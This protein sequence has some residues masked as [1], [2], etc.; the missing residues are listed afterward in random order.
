MTPSFQGDSSIYIHIPFCE[1]KCGYCDFYSVPRG[2]KEFDLQGQYGT[3][4]VREIEQRA[5]LFQ[6]K[7]QRRRL[8]SLFFGGGTPSL[9]RPDLLEKILRALAKYF[10][11]D[12]ATEVTLECN[13]KTVD[14]K[15]LKDFHSLGV[16]RLSVGVQSFQDRLLKGLGR[17]HSGDEAKKTVEEAFQAGFDNIN[18]DLIFAQSGE[19]FE[20][21]KRDLEEGILLGTQ[22]L[23]CYALTV[24][25]GTPFEKLSVR[26]RLGLPEEEEAIRQ[27][28]WTRERLTEAGYPPYEISNFARPGFESVHNLNYWRY[29][30]YLGFGAGAASFQTGVDVNLF[31]MRS[32]NARDLNAYL[33]GDYPIEEDRIDLKTAQGEFVM[34]GLR[35]R[36]GVSST[37]FQ[38]LFGARFETTFADVLPSL[39]AKGWMRQDNDH[40]CLT[41]PGILLA[42]E[43]VQMFLA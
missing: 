24:E 30:E 38:E 15:K 22:H 10:I 6:G 28:T 5:P 42:N 33:R 37:R 40:W 19:T 21:W 7:F 27:L 4:L 31:G 16:N 25:P 29:G 1:V 2:W 8:K 39:V 17:I 26:G 43:V 13:P 18:I 41:D 23:S 11:W 36:E 20:D 32:M 9:L 14:Q 35:T 12:R 34:L 3:S